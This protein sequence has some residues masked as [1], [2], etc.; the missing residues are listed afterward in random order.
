[1]DPSR[2][3]RLTVDQKQCLRLFFANLSIKEIGIELATSPNT[4]KGRLKSARQL[5]D[6][7]TSMKAAILLVQ[8]ERDTLGIDPPRSLGLE[9]QLIEEV[10]ATAPDLPAAVAINRLGVERL[11]RFGLIVA[12]AFVAVAFLGALRSG[13]EDLMHFFWAYRIDISD[14]PYRP[15]H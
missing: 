4:V 11:Q 8:H 3:E 1:M 13:L 15:T 14:Y 6:A 7:D 9:R 12:A 10:R 2:I 5:L